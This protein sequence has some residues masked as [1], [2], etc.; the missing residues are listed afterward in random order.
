MTSA[1]SPVQPQFSAL[2]RYFEFSLYFMLLVSV[3][4]LVS[5]GKLDLVS[6]LAAPALLLVKGYRLWRGRGPELSHRAST[7]L[8]IGYCAFFPVDL[9]VISRLISSDAQNPALFSA[10]LATVHLLL[11]A[12]V[13]RLYSART[14]RDYLFL[15]LLAFCAL[16]VSAILTVD[17]MFLAFFL[18]FMALCVSTFI[19]LEMRRSAEG[20]ISPPLESGTR[21][22]HRLNGA[23]GVT[24]A[25][26]AAA[27]LAMGGVIFFVIPRVHAGYLSGFNLQPSLIS[28]FSDDVE[29]G[30]IGQIKS[31]NAVVM[32]I[33]VQGDPALA[34]D[35]HW[36]GIVLT[37]F[38]GRRWYTDELEPV[39]V[40]QGPDR[41]I[42]VNESSAAALRYSIP[43]RYT[44]FLEPMAFDAVF[45]AN[46]PSQLTG[47]FVG[48]SG[49]RVPRRAYLVMDK[50]G[51]LSNPFHNFG[52]IRYDGISELPRIPPA[53]LR[54]AP[55]SYPDAMRAMYLQLPRLDPRIPALAK[56]ITSGARDPY[57]KARAVASYLRS[58][59]TYT[60]DLTGPPPADPLAYFLF[61]RRAG[62]CE[63]FATA[64]AVMLR[65]LGIPARY[66]NGFLPG[67]YND[68]G[69]DYIVRARDA[70]SWV[71]AFFPG[72][73]W[74][75]FDPT[76]PSDDQE[77][78]MLAQFG[79]YWDWFQMQWSEWVINYDFLHQFTLALGVQRVSRS[80]TE[81]L[82][83]KFEW[84]RDAGT[85][86]LRAWQASAAAAP[87]WALIFPVMLAAALLV[88]LRSGPLRERLLLAWRLRASHE[89]LP[90]H[91]AA[92]PYRHM[93]RLLERR[94]WSKLPAQTPLEFAASLP[95]GEFSEPVSELT[96]LYQA[97]RFGGHSADA[98]RVAT[99]LA[100][101]EAALSAHPAPR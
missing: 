34:Q 41:W 69:G 64:M 27:S 79:L 7:W 5:T 12:I 20:A 82:R 18:V 101:L 54:S 67:E 80:W 62:H 33:K 44:V 36:R 87:P 3:L 60:L 94:G 6:I 37:T 43:L 59:Y 65:S 2:H 19:G 91:A 40:S 66:V 93:L 8:V 97:A 72:Y 16:L 58:H 23:L 68:V 100:R 25:V 28:G 4:T 35:V 13:V 57:D 39:A 30:E 52:G 48:G 11:F 26:I 86:R 83:S 31:S 77:T 73:G 50:T 92:L 14:T 10:L 46:E 81:Q 53:V 17:M 49:Q 42:H 24:S 9:W 89:P 75:T 47:D 15:A 21:R 95:A 98:G 45:V 32:R 84:A 1:P 85:A 61:D 51:S 29:L 78:G 56:A 38:D 88:L 74:L 70:H 63:Y 71:E 76:P 96:R 22:A 99:L 55:A 90:P